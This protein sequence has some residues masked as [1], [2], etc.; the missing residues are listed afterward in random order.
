MTKNPELEAKLAAL[1]EELDKIPASPDDADLWEEEGK[2]QDTAAGLCH[3]ILR[4]VNR[5]GL[6]GCRLCRS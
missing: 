1:L 6:G 5:D 4:H 2:R 3:T